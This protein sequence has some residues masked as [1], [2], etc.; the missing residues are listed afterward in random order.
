M[1]HEHHSDFGPIEERIPDG[2]PCPEWN[3]Y[4]DEIDA[5]VYFKEITEKEVELWK[6]LGLVERKIALDKGEYS[7]DK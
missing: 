4:G 3:R 5:M 6:E 1:Y 7:G 2:V